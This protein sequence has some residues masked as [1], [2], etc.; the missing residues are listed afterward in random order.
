MPKHLAGLEELVLLAVA[1]LS[2]AYGVTVQERIESETRSR[3][4]IGAVY[5][6][7]DRLERRGYVRSWLGEATAA[8]GGR[9]KRLF[10]A[11]AQG[12][13]A[14]REMDRIR[15]SLLSPSPRTA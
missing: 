10:R 4:S 11:T 5:T 14:L 12:L 1:S 7:L 13:S 8:R 3:V 6:V 2:D 15:A 9:R